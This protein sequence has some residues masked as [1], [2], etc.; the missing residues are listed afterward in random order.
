MDETSKVMQT[1]LEAVGVIKR[2][3][4]LTE[5][6]FDKRGIPDDDGDQEKKQK[7]L[8]SVHKRRSLVLT[9]TAFRKRLAAQEKKRLKE[10]KEKEEKAE[11]QK[12]K[13]KAEKEAKEAE[14]EVNKRRKTA[15]E[16]GPKRVRDDDAVCLLCPV[17]YYAYQDNGLEEKHGQ[18][19]ENVWKQCDT[20]KR[21]FCPAHSPLLHG[22]SGHEK[23]CKI[24]ESMAPIAKKP[25]KGR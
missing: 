17:T 11:R 3:G 20:C 5:H 1:F 25:R 7:D 18:D 2:Y 10:E 14:K 16:K 4:E 21:W 13:R 6:W 22:A 15:I 23:S 24:F 8:R 9:H 19:K 12:N